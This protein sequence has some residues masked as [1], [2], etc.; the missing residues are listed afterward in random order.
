[1]KFDKKCPKCSSD[2][3]G[4]LVSTLDRENTST[5]GVRS[6]VGQADKEG[7]FKGATVMP[8]DLWGSLEAYV[9][10]ECGYFEHYVYRPEQVPFELLKGFSWVNK[11]HEPQGPFR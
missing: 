5:G 3:I 10:T 7:T 6:V 8:G 2:K 11:D 9:C 4:H 1:M